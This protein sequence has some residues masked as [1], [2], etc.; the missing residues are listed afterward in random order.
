M[1]ATALRSGNAIQKAEQIAHEFFENGNFKDGKHFFEI[2]G[3]KLTAEEVTRFAGIALKFLRYE[4]A[5]E[6]YKSQKLILPKDRA[7]T[8]ANSSLGEW[9]FDRVVE[10]MDETKNSF[11]AEEF[12]DFADA[13]F[14]TS[15]YEKALKLYERAGKIVS[16][17]EYKA[18]GEQILEQVRDIESSRSFYSS[19][20]MW[21]TI[22]S[23]FAYL[24]KSNINEAKQR[25]VQFAD[26]LL[27]QAD[28]AKIS[29]NAE[30]FVEIYKMIEMNMK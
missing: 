30:F 7:N 16:S 1:A 14:N 10:Y 27:E 9:I 20:V 23:A 5:L 17:D 15:K 29:S 24:S 18:K 19:G 8:I 13:I 28:F 22:S 12:K 3:K 2:T 11:T 25:I 21:P 26:S 6:L 4:D